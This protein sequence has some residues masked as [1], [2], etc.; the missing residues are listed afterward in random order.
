MR[1]S[2]IKLIEHD[3]FLSRMVNVAYSTVGI[4]LMI[5][6]ADLFEIV[7]DMMGIPYDLENDSLQ[8]AYCKM[9]DRGKEI[10]YDE[11]PEKLPE[12]AKKIYDFLL[13]QAPQ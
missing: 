12:L 7:F 2:I 1:T 5:Y 9:V 3:I 11:L 6:Q 10:A 13:T 4:D 8:V